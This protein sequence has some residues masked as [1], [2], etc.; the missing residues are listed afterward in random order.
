MT[1]KRNS[2]EQEQNS[3]NSEVSHDVEGLDE[4]TEESL[5]YEE[6]LKSARAKSEE[7]FNKLQRT[8]ADFINYK[9][10]TEQER[11]AFI[12]QAEA[13]L[14]LAMLPVLD[15]LE[16]AIENVPEDIQGHSWV[17]GV[18]HI[19]RKLKTT[20]EGRG[21]K[22]IEAVGT[23]FDPNY[24]DSAALACGEEDKVVEE[25][26]AGYTLYDKVLRPSTVL[27]GN[28]ETTGSRKQSGRGE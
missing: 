3:K 28:G 16:R 20:L 15:D 21:L 8:Q 11:S 10:R 19:Y 6:Q 2:K 4:K 25:I 9:R 18:K 7:Y 26:K 27:V 1:Q 17:E 23:L 5:S 22:R 12:K 14:M 24:H 13:D